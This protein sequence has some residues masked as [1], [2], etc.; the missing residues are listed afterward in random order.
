MDEIGRNFQAVEEALYKGAVELP[1]RVENNLHLY[2]ESDNW[3][4]HKLSKEDL[5]QTRVLGLVSADVKLARRVLKILRKHYPLSARVVLVHPVVY[6]LGRCDELDPNPID[7]VRMIEDAG[8]IWHADLKYFEEG[9]PGTLFDQEIVL[10]EARGEPDI[11]IVELGEMLPAR[12]GEGVPTFPTHQGEGISTQIMGWHPAARTL[13]E[14]GET[15]LDAPPSPVESPELPPAQSS[16]DDFLRMIAEMNPGLNLG[17]PVATQDPESPPAQS[18]DDDFLRTIA[19]M[20]PGLNL[21]VPVATQDSDL[22]ETDS[23]QEPEPSGDPDDF[24]PSDFF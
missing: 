6:L 16:N 10:R 19:E 8:A 4:L 12:E 24:D 23:Y 11:C 7:A 14:Q 18:S 17:L 15:P 20:N 3:I 9:D 22:S 1:P 13:L 21:G 2:I 5:S